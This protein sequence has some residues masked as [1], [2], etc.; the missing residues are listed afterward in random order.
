V[1]MFALESN[2][3]DMM[4]TGVLNFQDNTIKMNIDLVSKMKQNVSKI[5]LIGY[6]LVGDNKQPTITL[7]VHGALDDPEVNTSVYKEIIMT[8]FDILL[9][10]ISLPSHWLKQL[11]SLGDEKNQ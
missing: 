4:G 11:E 6:L 7:E 8:P 2:A 1:N 9:R 10:T 5:P 3:I